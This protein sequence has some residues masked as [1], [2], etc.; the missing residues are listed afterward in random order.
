[1]ILGRHCRFRLSKRRVIIFSISY[2]LVMYE[3]ANVTLTGS[4]DIASRNFRRACTQQATFRIGVSSLYTSATDIGP[5]YLPP[6]ATLDL[7][8]PDAYKL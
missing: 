7:N 3:M 2:N 8:P 4:L 1:L 5:D 6:S